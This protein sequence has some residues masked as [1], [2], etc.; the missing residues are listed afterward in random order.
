M[1][2]LII[3]A[4][5]PLASAYALVAQHTYPDCAATLG[6]V[7]VAPDADLPQVISQVEAVVSTTGTASE[8]AE[9][10]FLVD[11]QGATPANA[12]AR[13]ARGRPMRVL[14]G[15]NAAMLWRS[16]CY[17]SKPLDELFAL[18]EAGGQRG[19]CECVAESSVP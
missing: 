19:I 9:V 11:V 15:L 4:H 3:V 2:R 7:D 1:T 10:L 14:A 17:A 5:R 18:A 16:L 13:L 8:A 6:W 12:A